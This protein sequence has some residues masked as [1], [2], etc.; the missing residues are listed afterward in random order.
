MMD[1]LSDSL[2]HKLGIFDGHDI[3][4]Q[5]KNYHYFSLKL[6]FLTKTDIQ[7]ADCVRQPFA[8]Q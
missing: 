6:H 5:P 4:I 3:D 2:L 7:P 1:L 8:Q